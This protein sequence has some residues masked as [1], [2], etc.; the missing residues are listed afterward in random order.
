[1][2]K[3]DKRIIGSREKI[4]LKWKGDEEMGRVLPGSKQYTEATPLN[5]NLLDAL[6]PCKAEYMWFCLGLELAVHIFQT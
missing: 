4:F 3:Y 1:M 6:L 2:T 5:G